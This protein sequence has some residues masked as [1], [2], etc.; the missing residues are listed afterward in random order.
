MLYS[1][2]VDADYLDTEHFMTPDASQARN[3]QKRASIPE[4][5]EMLQA[6]LA[7]K[8]STDSPVNRARQ[9]VLSDCVAAAENQGSSRSRFPQEEGKRL[10]LL[11]LLSSTRS[12]MGWTA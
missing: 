12:N 3:D 10:A 11:L 8:S 5:L 6:H 7:T 2:L 9:A 4:L 1:S